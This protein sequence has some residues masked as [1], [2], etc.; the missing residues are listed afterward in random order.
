MI[1]VKSLHSILQF[2]PISFIFLLL[3]SQPMYA[4]QWQL[5]GRLVEKV[6]RTT[7][8]DAAEILVS[9]LGGDVTSSSLSDEEGR[10]A[11][12]LSSGKYVFRY[13]Q[14]GDIL[15]TDTL[16]VQADTDLGN[17][18]LEIK[19]Y[20]MKEVTVTSQRRMLSQKA[21]KLV[22]LV[23]NSPFAQGF[24]TR[25]LLHNIP[26]IDPTSEEIKIIGK[27]NVLVLVDGHRVNLEGKDLDMYLRTLPSENISKIELITNPSARFDAAGNSGVLNIILKSK[28]VGFDGK[29]HTLL[30]QRTHFAAEEGADLSFSSGN[31]SVEYKVDNSNEKRPQKMKSSYIYPTYTRVTND[32]T[33]NR[34]DILSQ[35]LNSSYQIGHVKIGFFS[36]LNRSR[37]KGFHKG[38]MNFSDGS[39]PSNTYSEQTHDKYRL[40]TI[41]PYVEWKLDSIGKKLTLNY[42]YIHLS[43]DV[44]QVYDS[45]SAHPFSSSW[46]NYSNV[47]NTLSADLNLPFTWLNFEVGGKY[48]HFRTNN[49]SDY[50]GSNGFLF[51]ETI[52]ALYADVHRN[53]G[54]FYAKAGLRYEHTSNNGITL[55]GLTVSN[56]YHHW[57]PFAEFSYNPSDD[58]SF[59]LGYSKRIN[60]PSMN[61]MDPTKVYRD[62]YSYSEGN[63][64]LVPSIMDNLEF[65]YVFK[66]NLNVDLYYY[67]TSDAI[68]SLRQVVDDL[69]TK[70]YPKNCLTINTYGGDVS[71]NFS[72]GK[73]N[74]YTSASMYYLKAKSMVEELDDSDLK[75]LNTTLSANLSYRYKAM[76]IFANY[77]HVFPGVEESF[78]T[79]NLDCLGLGCKINLLKNKLLLNVL[80]QDI[81]GGTKAHNR[82]A[83]N[84]YMFRNNI[85]N[86][87]TSLRVGLTY[88]FGKH[89]AKRTDVNIN[90]S[91]MNRLPDIKK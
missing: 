56:K 20:T 27:S 78:H 8:L 83:Y 43:D 74:L 72:W 57:F 58:H 76:T 46:D 86:D 23:Q 15:K 33:L 24:S 28:P 38:E 75:S 81:F 82:V 34:Y 18:P 85:D 90:N 64:R 61:N 49:I 87:N 9:P 4:Q 65:N 2:T 68:Q 36:T 71:Y 84:D 22:Y 53:F 47:V 31:F 3:S 80:A 59:S 69:Y 39:Y 91:E 48:S 41:S 37:N 16:D 25:D 52:T 77:Y 67:H 62:T 7:P 12:S 10:F 29:I 35:N 6:D 45:G 63:D 60:R 17:I 1:M 51:K 89:K 19:K 79:G 30:T 88:N 66:G 26:R 70:Y 11:L 14:L 13:R 5:K 44:N 42:N 40:E 54:P 32:Y 73:F 21:G 55:G 50:G